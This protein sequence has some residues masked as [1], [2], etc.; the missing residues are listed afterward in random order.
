MGMFVMASRFE[1]MPNAL[2]EAMACGL[3][4]ISADCD[5]GPGELIQDHENGILVP[6]EDVERLAAAMA[7]VADNQKLAEKLSQNGPQIRKTH[8]G[9]IIAAMYH[10]Y[11]A[12]V[13]EGKNK[14][15]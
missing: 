9:E 8:N 7:E 5:F 4:C 14:E 3:P 1:G 6:V 13:I 2:M 15:A 11:I 12:D 10:Q